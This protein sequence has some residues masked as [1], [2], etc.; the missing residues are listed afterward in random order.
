MGERTRYNDFAR[1]LALHFPFK[2]QKISLNVGFTCPNR[3][4]VKGYG[5]CTYC[6]NQTFNPAYC[7][8]DKPVTQQLEEGKEFFARKY[9]EM[10]FLAYFQAYTNTYAELDKLRRMYEE[11]LRV[12]G[13][14]GGGWGSRAGD[15]YA[16]RLYARRI[17]GLSGRVESAN[18]SFS[19]IWY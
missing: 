8:T 6:N 19:G 18:L 2:V 7:R 16:S 1:F 15:W 5:G 17:A 13:V 14:V 11:A 4:G 9:P 3:D 12:E 10:K